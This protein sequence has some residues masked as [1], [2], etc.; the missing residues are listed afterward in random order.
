MRSFIISLLLLASLNSFAKPDCVWST[1]NPTAPTGSCDIEGLLQF[2]KRTAPSH[3]VRVTPKGRNDGKFTVYKASDCFDR[4]RYPFCQGAGWTITATPIDVGDGKI[5]LLTASHFVR[6]FDHTIADKDIAIIL[7]GHYELKGELTSLKPFPIAHQ[8]P[9]GT[10][11]TMSVDIRKGSEYIPLQIVA[12]PRLVKFG[13]DFQAVGAVAPKN[14]GDYFGGESGTSLLVF[15]SI[16]AVFSGFIEGSEPYAF[17]LMTPASKI[18]E[19]IKAAQRVSAD[20]P[21]IIMK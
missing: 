20:V 6:Q 19:L 17:M 8:D 18:R 10:A 5:G 21:Y 2:S 15:G 11:V 4:K 7:P 3:T 12:R 9:R 14:M 1:E 16:Q 13:D